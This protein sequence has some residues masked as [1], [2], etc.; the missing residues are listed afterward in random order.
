MR[1]T[2]KTKLADEQSP[3]TLYVRVYNLSDSTVKTIQ[4]EFTTI[5]LQAGY[6]TGNFGVIFQGTIKQIATGRERNVD[7]YL[8][9][10][11]ADSDE[12]YNFAV[13]SLSLKSGQT[14]QQVINAIQS[15]PSV[16][17]VDTLPFASDA[18][19]L[20]AGAGA[21]TA[22]A[23]SRGKVLFGM[24]RDYARDWA[25]K[26]GYRW[27]MQ[28]GQFVV[29]PIT[30]YRPGEAVVLS[31]TTGLIGVP[32]ATNDG[33]KARALLNPLIRIGGLVQIQQSDIN[34]ITLQ[35]QGLQYSPAVATVTTAQGFYRVLVAEFEGDTRGNPWYVDIVCL[36]VD[37]SAKNPNSSVQ[38]FG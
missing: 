5:T 29:V 3:N 1:F 28:N 20:I 6:E 13:I 36:A 30:G 8:D 27:S 19:G 12:F 32:E 37:V 9:I 10:W 26:Y 33:V 25:N 34:Q 23:L 24:T 11:A 15:A 4:K 16:N 21:G 31:S 2:F 14:P 17:G 18:S 22:Q 38:A 35:Q 7:S